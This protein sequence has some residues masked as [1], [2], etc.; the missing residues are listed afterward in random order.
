[1]GFVGTWMRQETDDQNKRSKPNQ[2]DS[3]TEDFNLWDELS[4]S[5]TKDEN[6]LIAALVKDV[7]QPVY[8]LDDPL[9]AAR[10]PD[11]VETKFG[12]LRHNILVEIVDRLIFFNI[13]PWSLENLR[14]VDVS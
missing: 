9:V 2:N 5:E 7:E 13:L 12:I 8:S 1:M 10:K 14:S 4:G 3:F 11:L 6:P